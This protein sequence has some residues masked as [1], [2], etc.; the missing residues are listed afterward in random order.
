MSF[1]EW[2]EEGH[3]GNFI[4]ALKKLMPSLKV[5]TG[6]V[7]CEVWQTT[8]CGFLHEYK[9]LNTV[10]FMSQLCNYKKKKRGLTGILMAHQDCDS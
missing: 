2:L 10:F 7:S 9:L 1:N 8:E 4:N 3:C 5:S 6:D